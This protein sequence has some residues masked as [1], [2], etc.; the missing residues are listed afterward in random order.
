M[1]R[2]DRELTG[3]KWGRVDIR[4][5]VHV[6]KADFICIPSSVLYTLIL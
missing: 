4:Y 6:L 5:L 2:L 3:R 1:V